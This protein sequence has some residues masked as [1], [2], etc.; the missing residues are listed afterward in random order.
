MKQSITIILSVFIVILGLAPVSDAAS[1]AELKARMAQR[2]NQIVALKQNGSVGENN[3]GYLTARKALSAESA[4]LV[5]AENSDRR[6]VYQL[7]ANKTKANA[8]TVGKTR[9][10]SIRKS[11]PK[12]TWVQLVNGSWKQI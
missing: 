7:I 11:A 5:A 4:K 12:G 6:Q 1:A 3:L 2:L 8:A 9:A 10:A